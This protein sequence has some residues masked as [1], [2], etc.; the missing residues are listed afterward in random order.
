MIELTWIFPTLVRFSEMSVIIVSGP[1]DFQNGICELRNDVNS[2]FQW[3]A[4]KGPTPS[5]N[6]GP[7]FDHTT[8]SKQGKLF[9]T[10]DWFFT[11]KDS[12]KYQ[13]DHKLSVV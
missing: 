7:S 2:E 11:A 13:S 5:E 6:T 9:R 10:S 4:N 3:T 12:I 1:C 8:L